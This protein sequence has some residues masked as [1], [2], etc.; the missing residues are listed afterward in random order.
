MKWNA[1]FELQARADDPEPPGL[2]G[3][4]EAQPGTSQMTWTPTLNIPK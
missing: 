3:Q 2:L 1:S 4:G